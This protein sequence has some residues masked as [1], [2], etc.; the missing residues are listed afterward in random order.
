MKSP[1]MEGF[2]APK[3]GP[4]GRIFLFILLIGVSS[5][6]TAFSQE[7]YR[8]VDEKGTIHFTDDPTL[9]PERYRNQLEKKKISEKSPT[10]PKTSLEP[11]SK[12]QTPSPMAEKR[13]LLGRDEAWWR[14]KVKEWEDKLQQAQENLDRIRGEIRQKEKELAEVSSKPDKF[15]KKLKKVESEIKALQSE[16]K[17]WED[18][19]EEAKEM[20][21]KV[22]PKEATDFRADPDWLRPREGLKP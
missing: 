18:R 5:S 4:M 21:E 9:V 13:D 10:P 15:K 14:A 3:G 7:L 22:L 2:K 19:V 17:T 16:V 8:W 12:R 6:W 20:L 1:A 11:Q